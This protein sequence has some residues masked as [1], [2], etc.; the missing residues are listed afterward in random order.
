MK[1]LTLCTL[2][3]SGSVV[4]S[5]CAGQEEAV[6]INL[7]LKPVSEAAVG[8]P[9]SNV[10]VLVTPFVD[11][12]SDRTKLGM[13]QR[14][15]GTSHPVTLKNGSVGEATA[16]ALA[17]YL[18]RKGWHAKYV[19]AAT[20]VT[21]GD[22]IIS[23][24]VLESAVDAHGT[25][26]STDIAAKQKIVVHAKNQ[27]DGS[28]I[29]DTVSHHGTYSVFWF[30]G[31]DAEEILREVMEKNFDKFVSQTKFEGSALRFKQS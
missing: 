7:T 3:L 25:V 18:T 27:A 19:P 15:W 10:T 6:P 30:D 11:D 8:A 23:G 17:E 12:R 20:G 13:Y 28:S 26:G 22:V 29:T 4:V 21:G 24:K 1:L 9:A 5:G 31:E 14:W 2:V 16:T